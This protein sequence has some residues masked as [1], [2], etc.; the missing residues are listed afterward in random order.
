[1]MDTEMPFVEIPPPPNPDLEL[2]LMALPSASLSTEECITSLYPLLVVL[3][4][5][6]LVP[7]LFSDSSSS[8][9]LLHHC[10]LDA[11]IDSGF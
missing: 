7:G 8:H 11:F 1:M 10:Q 4:L 9:A 5:L 2:P 3:T 6:Y